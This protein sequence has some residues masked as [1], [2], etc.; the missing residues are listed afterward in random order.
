MSVLGDSPHCFLNVPSTVAGRT[1]T[2]YVQV[3]PTYNQRYMDV[4]VKM[5]YDA[6]ERILS[7][8]QEFVEAIRSKLESGEF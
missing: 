2:W 3:R 6:I 1:K 8:A 5:I 7:D 4:D